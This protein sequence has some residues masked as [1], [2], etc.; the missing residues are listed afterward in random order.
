MKASEVN[1]YPH[2]FEVSI[3]VVDNYMKKYGSLSDGEHLKGVEINL[4]GRIMNKRT[5][6]SKLYF[7]DLY[8]GGAKVQVM[9]DAS[10]YFK[11]RT[12]E[13]D[14]KKRIK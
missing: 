3:S 13:L 7:Y 9:A 4:A 2:K 14:G 11:I 12:I 6:S 1:L 5:S 8:G 10:I